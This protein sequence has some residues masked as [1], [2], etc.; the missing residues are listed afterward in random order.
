MGILESK[1]SVGVLVEITSFQF[2][3]SSVLHEIDVFIQGVT[4][5][6][7]TSFSVCAQPWMKQ[8]YVAEQDGKIIHFDAEYFTEAKSSEL[9]LP[10]AVSCNWRMCV[11]CNL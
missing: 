3:I 6:L 11:F 8:G 4:F 9:A 2:H 10:L 7:L 5:C 1:V